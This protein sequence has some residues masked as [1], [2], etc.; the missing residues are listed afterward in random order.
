TLSSGKVDREA[1][2]EPV[3]A[4]EAGRVAPATDPERLVATVWAAVLE[5]AAVWADDDFFALGG[6]SF[7]ATRVVGRLR[8]T[9]DLA[10]PVR[11]LFE[12]PVLA[13]FAAGLEEL[14]IAKLMGGSD[15]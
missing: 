9:L 4:P 6:H 12:R 3:D 14:L 7:A 2:P 8:D 10:V 11:L 13:D 5:R 15:A 1:L